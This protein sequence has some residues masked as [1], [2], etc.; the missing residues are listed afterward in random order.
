MSGEKSNYLR[1]RYL[2]DILL[3]PTP[4]KKIFYVKFNDSISFA[5]FYQKNLN[6]I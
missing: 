3:N 2:K 1:Q 6:P 4:L 5:S